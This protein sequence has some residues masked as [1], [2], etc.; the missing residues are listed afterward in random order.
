[1]LLCFSNVLL[2]YFVEGLFRLQVL[3]WHLLLPQVS[4]T[5]SQTGRLTSYLQTKQLEPCDEPLD[6]TWAFELILYRSSEGQSVFVIRF[7][8]S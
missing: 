4:P 8:P 2:Q 3:L 6:K 5:D 1:M 7:E